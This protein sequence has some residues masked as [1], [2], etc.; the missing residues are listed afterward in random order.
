MILVSFLANAVVVASITWLSGFFI[1]PGERHLSKRFDTDMVVIFF[2]R[3]LPFL[4]VMPM[5][6]YW[7]AD[8]LKADFHDR[9]AKSVP[10]QK[11]VLQLPLLTAVTATGGWVIGIFS[12]SYIITYLRP[13]TP[14]GFV[15]DSTIFS[16]V[17]AA[18]ALLI[19][20]YL[21]EFINRRMILPHISANFHLDSLKGTFNLSMRMRLAL[22]LLATVGLPLAILARII[23]FLDTM[24]PAD[25]GYLPRGDFAAL[26]AIIIT[27]GVLLTWLQ[28]KFISAPLKE[29]QAATGQVQRG[30]YDAHVSVTS[31]DEIGALAVD[32]N[33]MAK[34]LKE[35]EEMRDMFGKMVDP[36]V[37]DFLLQDAASLTGETREVT[38][39]FCDL[40][41]F[42][43]Y[44]EQNRPENVVTFLN[45]YFSVAQKVVRANGGIINK[46]IGDAFMALFNAPVPLDAHRHAA[47]K[48]ALDFRA[49]FDTLRASHAD[50]SPGFRIGI[51][52]GA[53]IAGR[54][55]SDDRQEY[56]VIGDAV[57][58]A[59]RIESLG[60]KLGRDILVSDAAA[61]GLEQVGLT[62]VGS[63]RLRGKSSPTVIFA[64]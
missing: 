56:T 26:L 50:G 59:S 34:G 28:S 38:I 61:A 52:T 54:I 35:R 3:V 11:R 31:G 64:L 44:S 23:L 1:S 27:I 12:F 4:V 40:A 15:V 13:G 21:L 55:G 7:F 5:I 18:M 30:D 47:V 36:S 42:T 16:W 32:I 25:S 60:K 37:R 8:C 10:L 58:V 53:V 33:A 46:F 41:G 39:L 24:K 2:S 14:P 20:Y 63:V 51:H 43:A 49:A 17:L 45:E 6:Y 62:R 19:M 57:N 9:V 48:T 29:M 22:H